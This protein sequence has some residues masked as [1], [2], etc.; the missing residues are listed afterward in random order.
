MIAGILYKSLVTVECLC[1]IQSIGHM[2]KIVEEIK[3]R[4]F[5]ILEN[6]M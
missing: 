6:K 3:I 5:G 2:A 4:G 1:S